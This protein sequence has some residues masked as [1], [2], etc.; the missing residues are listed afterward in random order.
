MKYA[1]LTV[2]ENSVIIL[3]KM[4]VSQINKTI[5]EKV[6]TK[7]KEIE[8][9]FRIVK[10]EKYL[11]GITVSLT[12]KILG[13]NL[14]GKKKTLLSD[15]NLFSG[16]SKYFWF[17]KSRKIKI[18]LNYGE[19]IVNGDTIGIV[20]HKSNGLVVVVKNGK[21][22]GRIKGIKYVDNSKINCLDLVCYELA[23]MGLSN[24]KI[25]YVETE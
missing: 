3:E 16:N 1:R 7:G 25:W 21:G 2:K 24:I 15:T 8:R 13:V 18:G 17:N 9:L 20:K 11:R 10:S 14:M 12:E 4:V 23:K 6:L 19:K 22:I 5:E